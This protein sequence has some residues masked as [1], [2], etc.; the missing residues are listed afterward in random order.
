MDIFL[1]PLTKVHTRAGQGTVFPLN[2]ASERVVDDQWPDLV[3]GGFGAELNVKQGQ[4]RPST[5]HIRT[6]LEPRKP[7]AEI[8][9]GSRV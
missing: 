8:F 1:V 4:Y 3:D 7:K 6:R 2:G 5:T 9:S